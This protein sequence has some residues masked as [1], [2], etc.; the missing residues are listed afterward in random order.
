MKEKILYNKNKYIV[1]IT[2]NG[3]LF[4]SYANLY[5][6]RILGGA[7]YYIKELQSK[8][9]NLKAELNIISSNAIQ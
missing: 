3:E 5:N 2:E 7:A 1:G 4:E 8:I 6:K 9:E